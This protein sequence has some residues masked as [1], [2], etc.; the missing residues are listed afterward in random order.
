MVLKMCVRY[1]TGVR[2]FVM[3][4]SNAKDRQRL[5]RR[6]GWGAG[7]RSLRL[8]VLESRIVFANAS[9]VVHSFREDDFSITGSF[10]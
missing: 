3:K 4:R 5:H 6:A 10:S 7:G 8:E 2:V 1:A 9:E